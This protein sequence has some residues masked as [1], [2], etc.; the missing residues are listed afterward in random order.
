M[1]KKPSNKTTLLFSNKNPT[2]IFAQF[3]DLISPHLMLRTYIQRHGFIDLD[4]WRKEESK[5]EELQKEAIHVC[6]A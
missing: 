2:L 6:F 5:E 1:Y 4:T 3:H